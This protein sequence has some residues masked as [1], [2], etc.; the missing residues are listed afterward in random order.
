MPVS[1]C[2]RYCLRYLAI[3]NVMI[4]IYVMIGALTLEGNASNSFFYIIFRDIFF[5]TL[6]GPFLDPSFDK[7][8]I[9]LPQ[10]FILLCNGQVIFSCIFNPAGVVLLPSSSC[11]KPDKFLLM[12]E[13]VG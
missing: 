1:D 10:A 9:F 3:H 6:L 8:V 4:T 12:S 7:V 5:G 2:R 13:I 11:S